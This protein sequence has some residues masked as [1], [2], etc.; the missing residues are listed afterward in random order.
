MNTPIDERY[1][2]FPDTSTPSSSAYPSS[3]LA[4]SFDPVVTNTLSSAT[5]PWD[6]KI[7]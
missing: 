5:R 7:F 6:K 2:V 1:F 3:S 4:F